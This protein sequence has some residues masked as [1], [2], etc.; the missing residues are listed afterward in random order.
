MSLENGDGGPQLPNAFTGLVE[1][2][3]FTF[4]RAS[5]LR[6]AASCADHRG[7]P[8]SPVFQ[9]NHWVTPPV[10]AHAVAANRLLGSRVAT[11]REVRD[12][13]PTLIAVD[14]ADRSDVVRVAAR[15]NRAGP[16]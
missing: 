15:V 12:R 11:C 7:V 16:A 1:E 8:G 14:F 10:P 6:G 2:T 4:L 9:L 3:P 13:V 5:D